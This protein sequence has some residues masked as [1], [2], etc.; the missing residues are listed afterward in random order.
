[1]RA[2]EIYC[3]KDY[4]AYGGQG[5]EGFNVT[6]FVDKIVSVKDRGDCTIINTVDSEWYK[7]TEPYD[8]IKSMIADCYGAED[9]ED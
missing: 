2:I 3:I 1:M 5:T 7:T 9:E 4:V 6:I 8:K